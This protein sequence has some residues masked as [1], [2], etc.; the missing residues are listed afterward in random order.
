MQI[1]SSLRNNPIGIFDSGIGGLTV[2][3]VI[4]EILPKEHIVYYGDTARLPYG[5]KSKETIIKFAKED[6][7]FLLKFNVKV[8]VSACFTVSSNAI[9]E[10]RNFYKIP[11]IDMI[12]PSIN[13][14][15]NLKEK[16]IGIIGTIATIESGSFQKYVPK[17][18]KVFQKACPLFVP[19]VEE[20]FFNHPIGILAAS[21]YL[22][23]FK[24]EGVKTIILGCT[25]YPLMKDTIKNVLGDVKF[26]E[27]GYEAG[28]FLK[29][30]LEK[31]NALSENEGKFEIYLS[32]IPRKMNE[33]LNI[34]MGDRIKYTIKKST[35]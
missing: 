21:E 33:I 2:A 10:L 30:L 12:E 17:G 4:K 31:N 3:K 35:D 22:E 34:F 24:K 13:I 27:P 15:K 16:K 29:K 25:H 6:I 28:I 7:D 18:I 11:I 26:I 9:S 8:I 19:I 5:N 1:D 14:L 20:G 32:D 23:E